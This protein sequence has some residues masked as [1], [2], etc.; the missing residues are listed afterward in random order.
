MHS[1]TLLVVSPPPPHSSCPSNCSFA[2]AAILGSVGTSRKNLWKAIGSAIQQQ[3]ERCVGDTV[4]SLSKFSLW[5]CWS[6]A[7]LLMRSSQAGARAQ[8]EG[9]CRDGG[10]RHQGQEA[11]T[12]ISAIGSSKSQITDIQG[13]RCKVPYVELCQL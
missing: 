7:L 9:G 13:Y 8:G 1:L 2:G 5:L 3:P 11:V 6:F 10:S 4:L 12:M